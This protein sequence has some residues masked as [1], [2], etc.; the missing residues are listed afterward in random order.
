[1]LVIELLRFIL[2]AYDRK[3]VS[4]R[5]DDRSSKHIGCAKNPSNIFI[6]HR[7]SSCSFL[8][9]SIKMTAASLIF[10]NNSEFGSKKIPSDGIQFIT[11]A[12]L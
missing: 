11:D 2:P 7:V 4:L 8:D 9:L 10:R 3:K 6:F 5:F 12:K 1:V